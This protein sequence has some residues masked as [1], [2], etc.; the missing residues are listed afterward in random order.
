MAHYSSLQWHR[1]PF[2]YGT[3]SW[4]HLSTE[5]FN[6]PPV[7][8]PPHPPKRKHFNLDM[9][10]AVKHLPGPATQAESNNCISCKD[11]EDSTKT[12]NT[13]FTYCN[14]KQKATVEYWVRNSAMNS[15]HIMS[16]QHLSTQNYQFTYCSLKQ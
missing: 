14:S 13:L 2:S 11:V 9:Q 10:Q 16:R 3:F 15:L 8:F 1:S 12:T 4:R 7:T 5:H 6:L